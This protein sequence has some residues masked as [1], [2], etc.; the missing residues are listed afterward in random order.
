MRR[1]ELRGGWASGPRG[2]R[3]CGGPV[4]PGNAG[5]VSDSGLQCVP[6]TLTCSIAVISGERTR[7][8]WVSCVT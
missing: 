5:A 2:D 8:D 6:F 1:V 3:G 7:K 4:F